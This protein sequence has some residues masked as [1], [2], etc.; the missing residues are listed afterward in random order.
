MT[1]LP[2]ITQTLHGAL[3]AEGQLQ[4]ESR[5]G[6]RRHWSPLHMRQSHLDNACGIHCLM[7]S[8]ALVART[9]R[10]AL[11]K[12][13]EVTRGPWRAFWQRAQETYFEGTSAR[14]LEQCVNCLNGVTTARKRV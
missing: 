2:P 7:V 8:L 13:A 1:N 11:E 6:K 5:S 3:R 14:D 9:P 4:Y 12:V 10:G